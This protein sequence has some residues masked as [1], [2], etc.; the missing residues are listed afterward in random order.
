MELHRLFICVEI[1]DETLKETL[2]SFLGGKEY[3]RL[4]H[5]RKDQ[6]H[7]TLKF[8]GDTDSETLEK[9]K[10]EL[11][12][13]SFTSF[14]VVMAGTGCFPGTTRPRIVWV[15]VREGKEELISIAKEI[16]DKM[17]SLGYKKEKRSF[18][19]H[20]TIARVKKA[21]LQMIKDLQHLVL[22]N[23]ETVFGSFDVSK[24]VLKKSTLTPKG[25][26]YEDI[27]VISAAD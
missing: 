20:L 19:P 21:D 7:L 14:Q 10:L 27:Q 18:K 17:S 15:G 8:L 13:I 22:S 16:D 3:K 24:I 23:A 6:M 1:E 12:E 2:T 4:K 26:I 11:G 9:V 5:A 25:P